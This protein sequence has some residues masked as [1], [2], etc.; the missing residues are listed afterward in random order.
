MVSFTLLKR[1]CE[2]LETT[3][4]HLLSIPQTMPSAPVNRLHAVIRLPGAE[5]EAVI[6]RSHSNYASQNVVEGEIN[7]RKMNHAMQQA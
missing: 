6:S 2:T 5:Q 4:T 3:A 7:Q 1:D